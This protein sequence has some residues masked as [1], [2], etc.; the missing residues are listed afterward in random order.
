M[1]YYSIGFFND[2]VY[3]FYETGTGI[4]SVQILNCNKFTDTGFGGY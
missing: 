3:L 4:N 2:L 1:F